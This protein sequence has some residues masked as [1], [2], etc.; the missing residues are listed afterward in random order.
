ML[1]SHQRSHVRGLAMRR[2]VDLHIGRNGVTPA[3]IAELSRILDSHE[4]AKLKFGE[5]DN[6]AR[7]AMLDQLCT[8]TGATLCG[9][10]GRT[11]SLYRHSPSA[12]EHVFRA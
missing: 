7:K 5:K 11:A 8:E 9:E 12:E 3:V 1:D 4:V 10:V 2:D 6:T